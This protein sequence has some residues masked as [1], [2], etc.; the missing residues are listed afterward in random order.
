MNTIQK[1]QVILSCQILN[2]PIALIVRKKEDFYVL[3][4]EK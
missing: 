4:V 1:I 3:T 2:T